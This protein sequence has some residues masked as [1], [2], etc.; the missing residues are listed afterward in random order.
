MGASIRRGGARAT[1]GFSL[2]ELVVVIAIVSVLATLGF[3]LAELAHKRVQEQELRR[4]LREIRDGLD[5]YKKLVD[6][7]RIAHA[8]D[9]SG[10]PPDL[11]SLVNGV[12]DIQS[13]RGDKIYILRSLPSDP[14]A[15]DGLPASATWS[16]RSYFSPPDKPEP[17]KDVFDVHS[18]S[19]EKGLNG[20]AYKY[21]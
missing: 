21:W 13:P 5:A 3:P 7:G 18:M 11:D 12:T 4:A 1:R 15:A 2:I 10:Y 17:G 6:S 8:S 9:D 16:T 19:P 20:I 14:F